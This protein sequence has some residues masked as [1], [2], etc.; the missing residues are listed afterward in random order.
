MKS[1][2]AEICKTRDDDWGEEVWFRLIGLWGDFPAEEVRYHRT[3]FTTFSLDRKR[4]EHS[5]EGPPTRK[6]AKFNKSSC[7]SEIK[8]HDALKHAIKYLQDNDNET[9]TLAELYD[10]MK[11]QSDLDETDMYTQKQMHVKLSE[12]IKSHSSQ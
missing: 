6:K 5:S 11:I 10:G 7:S 3:C 4:P 1:T 9:I 12:H 8:K 2:I